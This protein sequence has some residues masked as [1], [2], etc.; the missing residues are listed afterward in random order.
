MSAADELNLQAPLDQLA[1]ELQNFAFSSSQL[2]EIWQA[3]LAAPEGVQRCARQ[4]Q[5]YGAARGNNGAGLLLTM[6]RRGDHLHQPDPAQPRITGWRF[7]RGTHSGTY[8]EHPEGTDELPPRYDFATRS[9]FSPGG[10]GRDPFGADIPTRINPLKTFVQAT[11]SH[12]D[13][14]TLKAELRQKGVTDDELIPLLDLAATIRRR[15][16]D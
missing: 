11:A 3:H 4:A 10:R 7:V 13:D 1:A 12:Y 2:H 6:L 16:T 14:A 8:I 15:A 9:P 5:A